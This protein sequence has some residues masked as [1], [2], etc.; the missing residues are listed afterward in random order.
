MKKK[1]IILMSTLALTASLV[2]CGSKEEPPV[3]TPETEATATPEASTE[4]E[5]TETPAES[6]KPETTKAPTESEKPEPTEAPTESEEPETTKAPEETKT[7]VATKKPEATKK[8]VATAKPTAKPV[9]TPKPTAKPTATPAPTPEPTKAPEVSSLSAAQIFE[10]TVAGLQ[11]PA[12][13]E[14]DATIIGDMYGID[15]STLKSFKVVAPL[16]SA[17]IT[18]IAIFE[19]KD[20]SGID[21]VKAG[22][23]KRTGGMDM[24]NM[25]PSLHEAFESRQT[26]VNGNY[27]LFA[28]DDNINTLVANFNAAIK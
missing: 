4:P 28:M 16:M 23:E 10:K 14:M 2:G 19:V 11:L 6:E 7:P 22:I 12:T 5:E 20:A 21:A 3:T 27:V 18:E 17:S 13:M 24:S 8:P 15:T 25:Y 9:A 1:F 26:V